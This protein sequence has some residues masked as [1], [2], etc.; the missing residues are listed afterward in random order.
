[1][2]RINAY[3]TPSD[4]GGITVDVEGMT[5]DLVTIMK[6]TGGNREAFLKFVGDIYDAV[7]VTITIPDEHKQ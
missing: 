7:E 6:A 4:D 5:V 2:D 3:I 1:M